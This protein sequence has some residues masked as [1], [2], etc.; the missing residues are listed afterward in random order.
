MSWNY[1]VM[2]HEEEDPNNNW[3][4]VHEVFYTSEDKIW[5]WT[6]NPIEPIGESKEEVLNILDTMK[7][8][9]ENQE[10]LNYNMEPEGSLEDDYEEDDYC[11]KCG[12]TLWGFE[13]TYRIWE[14]SS[15]G[16]VEHPTYDDGF[17]S[18]TVRDGSTGG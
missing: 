10:V 2:Y 4:G 16:Y 18:R 7:R 11:P 12:S 15:C 6:E 3:Y 8:D 5:A 1:R 9:I 13:I 17:L 14:C